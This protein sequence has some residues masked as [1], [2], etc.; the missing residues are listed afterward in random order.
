M[1]SLILFTMLVPNAKYYILN[2]IMFVSVMCTLNSILLSVQCG[3]VD[4]TFHTN[5]SVE[6]MTFRS[7]R[8]RFFFKNVVTMQRHGMKE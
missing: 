4:T 1:N 7:G 8:R 6:K 3:N 5:L 2:R